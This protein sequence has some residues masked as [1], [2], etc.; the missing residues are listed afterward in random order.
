MIFS[1]ILMFGFWNEHFWLP[2]NTTWDTF[3]SN[4]NIR[5]PEPYELQYSVAVGAI[6]VILRI[7]V[8]SIIFLP[9]GAAFGWV[10][11]NKESLISRVV[12]HLYLG[13]AGN[14]KFKRV[15]ESAWR[16]VYYFCA[17]IGGYFVLKNEPQ[18]YDVNES[19]RDYPH[20]D[21]SDGIWWYYIIE[22]G[23][24]WSLLFRLVIV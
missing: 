8:E 24:Y 9:I 16:F 11:T 1:G 18:F 17:F 2:D 22:T 19:W 20:Q 14:R 4:P 12:H 15:A 10:D 5:Y 13:F 7:L 3:K 23:F 21:V 6:L